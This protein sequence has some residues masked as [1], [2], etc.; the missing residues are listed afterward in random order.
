MVS[1]FCFEIALAKFHHQKAGAGYVPLSPENP[2]ERN[3]YMMEDSEAVL[4]ITNEYS[5]DTVND[6]VVD[7]TSTK[8]SSSVPILI[9]ENVF[10]DDGSISSENLDDV[11]RTPDDLAYML[12]TSGT[13]GKPKGCQLTHRNLCSLIAQHDRRFG[14]VKVERM[15][16]FAAYV[17]DD[18]VYEMFVSLLSGFTL[19]IAP[20]EIRK[21]VG[22]GD[23]ILDNNIDWAQMTPVLAQVMDPKC[24]RNLKKMSVGGEAPSID[25][26]T[27][28]NKYVPIHN[29]IGP[30]ECTVNCAI[31]H[32]Q[33]GDPANCIG[34]ALANGQLYVLDEHLQPVPIGVSA[35]LT[36]LLGFVCFFKR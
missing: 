1:H 12:Y 4:V 25:L 11:F 17:F 2:R 24:F 32:W 22:L 20:E 28:L 21:D 19:V 6:F 18:S 3:E 29:A 31:H 23:F 26:L 10:K 33:E 8:P 5:V 9:V 27:T 16:F 35:S 36:L 34:K 30:T 14:D 7:T 15:L 13:T